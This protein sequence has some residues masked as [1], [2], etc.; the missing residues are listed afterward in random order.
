MFR[1]Y[2]LFLGMAKPVLF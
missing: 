1:D 2:E